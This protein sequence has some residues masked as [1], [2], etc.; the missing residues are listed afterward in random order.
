MISAMNT[1]CDLTSTDTQFCL[2]HHRFL[3]TRSYMPILKSGQ[4]T[5]RKDLAGSIRKYAENR[6]SNDR[7][8]VFGNENF[9]FCVIESCRRVTNHALR[10]SF[11]LSPRAPKP[12]D[13]GSIRGPVKADD[14]GQIPVV[15]HL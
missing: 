4:D 14:H 8:I 6:D 2:D 3:Q 9:D 12:F 5:E 15:I 1:G 13:L 7:A 10:C 11:P